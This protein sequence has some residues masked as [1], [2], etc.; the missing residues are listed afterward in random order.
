[1]GLVDLKAVVVSDEELATKEVLGALTVV[2]NAALGSVAAAALAI[3]PG[4]TGGMP[5]KLAF[6]AASAAQ[7]ARTTEAKRLGGDERNK[8][9]K[10]REDKSEAHFDEGAASVLGVS[11][12]LR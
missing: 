6:F 4:A 9:S 3:A 5:T 11:Y 10:E 2:L 1:M 8:E 7:E 12:T